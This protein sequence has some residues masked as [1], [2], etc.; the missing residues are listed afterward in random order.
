[1]WEVQIGNVLPQDYYGL[2]VILGVILGVMGAFYNWF[3]LYVQSLYKKIPKIGTF[4]KLL[5]PFI[6][7]GIL[8]IVMPDVL[9]SGHNL[10][11]EL[12]SHEYIFGMVV[13]IFV[14]R[15]IFS[16]VSF[17]SGA[18]GGIFFPLL[19]LG[20][21]I[22]G[23][24]GM[25]GVKVFG[26]NPDYVNNFVLLA[27]A[28]YF[29]AIVRAPLTGI[30]LIFEMTGSV[31]QMLSLSVISIVAYIV[32]TLMKS[33]PIYESLLER[34]LEKNGE[35]VHKERG[36]K[37]LDQFSVMFGS[38]VANKAIQDVQWPENCL[39]V[40]IQRGGEEIIPRGKTIL[41]PSD[42]IV[43][44]TDERDSGAVYDKMENLCKEHTSHIF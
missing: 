33:K 37:I 36:E 38:P 21:F 18:P 24:F 10:V 1:S 28:G 12:T 22:G 29:T 25:V 4:G 44:M 14:I 32:A 41:R 5:I 39:L 7:A 13:L 40:A 34:L 35:P 9:G 6:M 23:I 19:V 2:I 15:F 20:A 8:G 17:G 11:E 30:I 3:T 42:V 27:M 26:M 16:A 31:S 43:T